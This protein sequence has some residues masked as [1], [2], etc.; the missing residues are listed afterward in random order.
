[1]QW[2]VV[3]CCHAERFMSCEIRVFAVMMMVMLML[4]CVLETYGFAVRCQC[5][6]ETFSLHLQLWWW[7]QNVS[8]KRFSSTWETTRCQN[9]EHY[10]SCHVYPNGKQ[11]FALFWFYLTCFCYQAL[12]SALC[13]SGSVFMNSNCDV[14]L[15]CETK[16]IIGICVLQSMYML[17]LQWDELYNT[18]CS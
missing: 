10:L 3:S 15:K 1:M 5:F 11:A 12:N 7:R 2:S 4:F 13:R 18:V 6:G 9:R 8:P 16:E 17:L 14:A